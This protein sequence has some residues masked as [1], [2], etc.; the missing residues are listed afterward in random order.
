MTD[1]ARPAVTTDQLE[2]S[3]SAPRR[4]GYDRVLFAVVIVL[5]ALGIVLVY[6]ASIVSAQQNFGDAQHYLKRQSIYAVLTLTVMGVFMNVH[7]MFWARVAKWVLGAAILGLIMVL[8]PGL[9]TVAK[10]AARWISLGPIRIQPSEVVKLA[11]LI[12]LAFFVALRKGNLQN[13]RESWTVPLVCMCIIGVLLMA[14]PDFG[15]TVICAGMMV[16]TLWVGGA[17]WLHMG[18]LM[19]TGAGLAVLAVLAE[20]YR[21][22]RIMAFLDSSQDQLNVSYH[23]RQALISFGSGSWQGLGLGES[24]QKLFYLP[25]A[26]T[27]FVFSILGEELGFI[28]VVVVV[29]LYLIFFF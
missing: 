15:S 10:G 23:I 7:Y 2:A 14:Q 18:F 8:I 28:G 1:L 12:F 29:G 4:V 25:E 20:P 17:R 26:H 3:D 5:M 16:L 13:F 9:S 24:R 6:S 21:M 11:W 19:C 22:K 27:D